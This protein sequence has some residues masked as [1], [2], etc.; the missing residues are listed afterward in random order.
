MLGYIPR[1]SNSNTSSGVM[2]RGRALRP[3]LAGLRNLGVDIEV[4]TSSLGVAE[5]HLGDPEQSYSHT[6]MI[7]MWESLTE[8][9]GDPAI[10]LHAAEHGRSS[11]FEL[12]WYL[13]RSSGSLRDAADP[14]NHYRRLLAEAVDIEV[15]EQEDRILVI[16]RVAGDVPMPRASA[17]YVLATA[18]RLT[19]ELL[20]GRAPVLEVCFRIPEPA[21]VAEYERIFRAPIR[22]GM[23]HNGFAIGTLSDFPLPTS[24]PPLLRV[25]VRH[26]DSLLKKMSPHGPFRSE[27]HT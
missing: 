20:E 3:L 15:I 5:S 13:L 10:G 21:E 12:I 19:R 8:A 9:S 11:D 16:H 17:D 7:R 1:V 22:F 24:D 23:D 25:L 18:V 4:L 27:E 26:A 14:F 2:I 6:S